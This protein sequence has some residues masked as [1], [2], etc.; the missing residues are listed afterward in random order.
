MAVPKKDGFEIYQSGGPL[1]NW[2]WRLNRRGRIVA[3]GSEGYTR[4]A[5]VLRAVRGVARWLRDVVPAFLRRRDNGPV[6]RVVLLKRDPKVVRKR[7]AK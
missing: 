7:Q 6:R 4:R 2:F 1:G 3:D 5:D